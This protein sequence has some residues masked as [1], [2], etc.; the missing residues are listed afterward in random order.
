M[1]VDGGAKVN[2]L[3]ENARPSP[4]MRVFQ[5]QGGSTSAPKAC[6]NG[7]KLMCRKSG[8]RAGGGC[9]KRDRR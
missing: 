4:P 3:A 2:D 9:E 6:H 8:W 1:V 7:K 5:A